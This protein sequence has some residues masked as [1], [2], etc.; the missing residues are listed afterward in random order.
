M[1][2]IV[3]YLGMSLDGYI[4][5]RDG[6]VGWMAGDGSE[7]GHPG[8]YPEF[9]ERVDTVILGYRT[10]RQIREELSPDR[11]MYSGKE[12][13]VITHRSLESTKEVVFTNEAPGSLLE[14]LK[15]GSGGDIWICG[16]AEIVDQLIGLD[17][18]D[19]YCVSVLPTILGGGISLFGGR[20]KELQLKLISTRQYDGIVDLVYERR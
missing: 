19:R 15:A 9:Y 1:R 17:L 10:Y 14:K 13:Y 18:I 16:G 2:D 8:S 11:W 20:E 3:L 12:C 5:D 6:G 7:P 4:A